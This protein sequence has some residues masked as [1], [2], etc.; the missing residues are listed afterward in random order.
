MTAGD[1]AIATSPAVIDR[2]YSCVPNY[3]SDD[4]NEEIHLD[5]LLRWLDIGNLLPTLWA[6]T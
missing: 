4:M 6:A 1:P 2:R 5:R 3:A